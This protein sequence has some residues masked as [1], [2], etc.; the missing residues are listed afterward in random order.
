LKLK[1][2]DMQKYRNR[3]HKHLRTADSEITHPGG[4]GVVAIQGIDES[5]IAVDR[6]DIPE[7]A[8]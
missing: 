2:S 5:D 8:D 4:P 7:G 6:K 3:I 1:R